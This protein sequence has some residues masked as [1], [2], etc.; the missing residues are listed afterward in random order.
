MIQ[1]IESS[2]ACR[3]KKRFNLAAVQVDEDKPSAEKISRSR[4][5]DSLPWPDHPR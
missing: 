4:R 2:A 5:L 3:L 1:P